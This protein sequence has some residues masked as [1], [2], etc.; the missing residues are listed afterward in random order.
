[1]SASDV[2]GA[3]DR[4]VWDTPTG[5]LLQCIQDLHME[6]DEA[7]P[8]VFTRGKAYQVVSMHPV[9]DPPFVGLLSDQGLIH[10]MRAEHLR[11]WFKRT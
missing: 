3:D 4:L 11:R 8:R 1:M 10:N 2:G 7:E 9:A 5:A 6:E